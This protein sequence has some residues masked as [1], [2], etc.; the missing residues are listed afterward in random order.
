MDDVM[1]H[2]TI[3]SNHFVDVDVGVLIGGGMH[4]LVRNKLEAILPLSVPVARAT[5]RV[6]SAAMLVEENTQGD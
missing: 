6:F 5:K 4:H 3:E 2:Y 1:G